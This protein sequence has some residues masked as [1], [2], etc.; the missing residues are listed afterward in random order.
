MRAEFARLLRRAADRLDPP[1]A[2]RRTILYLAANPPGATNDE[3]LPS[4]D[5][6]RGILK[7]DS[8]PNLRIVPPPDRGG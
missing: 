8:G 5:E 4:A 2:P 3:K 7:H 6:V 1:P